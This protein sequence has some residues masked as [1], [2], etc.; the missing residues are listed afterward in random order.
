MKAVIS[1]GA[2]WPRT[3]C[4]RGNASPWTDPRQPETAPS[5]SFQPRHLE[6]ASLA[7]RAKYHFRSFSEPF[8]AHCETT[9]TAGRPEHRQRKRT[10]RLLTYPDREAHLVALQQRPANHC[11]VAYDLLTSRPVYGC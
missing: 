8:M 5:A 1:A 4:G 11:E 2:V 9:A 7:W 6:V 10:E 3:Q